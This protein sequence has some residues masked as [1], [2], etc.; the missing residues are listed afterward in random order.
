IVQERTKLEPCMRGCDE[1][2]E[3][4]PVG[5]ELVELLPVKSLRKLQVRGPGRDLVLLA[6]DANQGEPIRLAL[7]ADERAIPALPD[8]DLLDHPHGGPSFAF[9][10]RCRWMSLMR[11]LMWWS[12][13]L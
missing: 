6:A 13:S 1:L 4:L 8:P 10:R 7:N 5:G 11:N 2:L 3:S 12:A 9:R